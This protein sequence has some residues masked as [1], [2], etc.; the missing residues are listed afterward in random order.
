[1]KNI[2]LIRPPATYKYMDLNVTEDPIITMLIYAIQQAGGIRYT[3]FDFHL[4]RE[5]TVDHIANRKF[6]Y[7]IIIARET[8]ETIHYVKRIYNDLKN[9]VNNIKSIVLY[10]QVARNK[11]FKEADIKESSVIHNETIL[12]DLVVGAKNEQISHF[13][14]MESVPYFERINID[15]HRLKIFKAAIET[16]RGCQFGCKFCFINQGINYSARWTVR[17]VHR[18]LSDVKKYYDLGVRDYVF[19]ESEFLGKNPSDYQHRL[20]L[21]N[22]LIDQFPGIR[23]QIYCRADTLLKFDQFELLKA[24]GLFQVFI[25][26]ESLDQSDLDSLNKGLLVEDTIRCVRKLH[27]LDVYT[28]LSFILFNRNTS[29][30]T[31]STTLDKLEELISY[32]P[33]LC[34]VPI[35]TFSFESNWRDKSKF[36]RAP[37]SK[38][39][40][41]TQDLLQ[42]E[43]P[44]EDQIFDSNLEALMEMYRVLSYEWNKKVVT[45]NNYR[46]NFS[47]NDQE[48][49]RKWFAFLPIFCLHEMKLH[50]NDFKN[51]ELTVDRDNLARARKGLFNRF[52][53][54]NEI[55][56]SEY[57]YLETREA[58]GS[59]LAHYKAGGVIE[60]D[61]YWSK[62]I[63]M[64]ECSVI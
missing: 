53:E 17:S 30:S 27:E 7:Y 4:E 62:N 40:Y 42:K 26:V 33:W 54:F 10:G 44:I 47:V 14:E 38:T 9:R 2:C 37:L 28:S 35:F 36:E 24:S 16:S 43:Q 8:G 5:L 6:D 3:V 11:F 13:E 61:E 39:T 29:V 46:G 63:A 32:K 64:H 55:L 25:G 22:A 15:K 20:T 19:H 45:L 51:G 1:M 49:V 60:V 59:K 21:L 41:V 18:V 50:L 52:S 23:Y 34:G 31:L 12:L 48:C 58:H 56:P 57:R